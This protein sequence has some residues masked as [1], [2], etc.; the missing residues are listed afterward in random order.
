MPS[1][2]PAPSPEDGQAGPMASPPVAPSVGRRRPNRRPR[3]VLVA[4]A[5]AALLA[6][7]AL[8]VA[9][10][11]GGGLTVRD[12]WLRLTDPTRPLGGFM[13]IVNEGSDTD[14]LVGAESPAFGRIELHETAPASMES[15]SPSDHAGMA[16]P[17]T[18][19]P[20]EMPG[21]GGASPAPSGEMAM[22]MRPVEEIPIPA[23]GEQ[24]LQP[25]GYHLML[26]EP[27]RPLV[28]GDK[29]ELTLRFRSGRSVTI[30][31][32]VRAP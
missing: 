20:S 32:S 13:T 21:H 30:E 6:L 31:V 11:A 3:L 15:P 16:T 18:G 5:R 26:M 17:S 12:P 19:G 14:A 24:V 25:G 4:T 27:T 23:R 28:V 9:A 2:R 7:P 29:I 1:L 10:C 22:T 8:L